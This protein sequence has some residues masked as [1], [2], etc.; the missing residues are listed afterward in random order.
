M[1]LPWQV[2]VSHERRKS[3]QK[4][5]HVARER[6]VR[7]DG[8]AAE[9]PRNVRLSARAER[10]SICPAARAMKAPA[11]S[12][13]LPKQ[14]ERPMTGTAASD[15]YNYR[16]VDASLA[17]SGQPT[18]AQL[19]AVAADGFKVVINL[20]LHDDPRYSL[21]DEAGLISSLG[22]TYVHIPVVFDAPHEAEL[23]EFFAAIDAHQDEKTLVHCAANKRVSTF[24]GLYRVIRQGWEP[25][26][27]FALMNEIW[28][29][30]PVWSAF[31]ADTLSRHQG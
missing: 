26:K 13:R 12:T 30:D 11:G 23:F 2:A 18:E 10:R 24:L 17:T 1:D 3:R 25:E 29:P 4:R 6:A 15:I 5:P 7:I 31:V 22:L 27:A 19:R 14:T 9:R 28:V 16:R 8:P 20:A 21:P